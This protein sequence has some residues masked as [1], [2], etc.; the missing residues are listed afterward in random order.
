MN[1]Y[2]KTGRPVIYDDNGLYSFGGKPL[3]YIDGDAVYAYNGIQLG[4]YD[5]GWIRDING[6]CVLFTEGAVGGPVKPLP[7]MPHLKSL[8]QLKPL[9]GIKQPKRIKPIF[10]IGWSSLDVE[11]LFML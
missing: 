11:R 2:D 10:K 4:W 6:A 7:F 8:K 3:G 1:Y 5:Q 9:K